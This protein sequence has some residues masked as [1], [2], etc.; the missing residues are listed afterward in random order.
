MSALAGTADA[1]WLPARHGQARVARRLAPGRSE[2]AAAEPLV[3]MACVCG[4][5]SAAE[6]EAMAE[7][8]RALLDWLRQRVT[9]RQPSRDEA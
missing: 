2:P 8:G 7:L 9:R 4:P 6:A 1:V 3:P 5:A